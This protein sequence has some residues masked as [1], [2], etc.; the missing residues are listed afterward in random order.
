MK[1]FLREKSEQGKQAL[2][3]LLDLKTKASIAQRMG[4]RAINFNAEILREQPFTLTLNMR[5]FD[6]IPY[7]PFN[8]DQTARS[9]EGLFKQLDVDLKDI[10]VV[11]E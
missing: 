4:L 2:K 5:H 10:E 6:K 11:C 7:T 3:N 9:L 8:A 1:V